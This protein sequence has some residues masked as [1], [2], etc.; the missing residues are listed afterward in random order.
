[1][2]RGPWPSRIAIAVGAVVVLGAA[3][4]VIVK[5]RGHEPVASGVASD[6]KV[7]IP[8]RGEVSLIADVVTP[9]G[10]GR[11][12]LVIMPT[13]WGSEITEY[14]GLADVLARDGYQVVTYVQR[15]FHQSGGQADFAGPP[16]QRDVSTVIDWAVRHTHG[17][18]K[19]VGLFGTSYGAGISLLAAA[20]DPRIKAVV[21]TSGWA[22]FGDVFAG[23]DTVRSA[24]L[25][26]LLG[27]VTKYGKPA[28]SLRNLAATL[29]SNRPADA[30]AQIRSMSPIR[31]ADREIAALNRNQPAIMLTSAY[32][33]SI[34]PPLS[35][36]SFFDRL[37]GP[38]RLQLAPG[39]HG[40]PEG[41]GLTGK[42]NAVTDQAH[43]W[44]DH[45]LK[46][47]PNGID[48]EPAVQ[49]TDAVTRAV[50]QYAKW[51]VA[52]ARVV[53]GRP[54]GPTA[55]ASAAATTWSQAIGGGTDTNADAVPGS[56]G[57]DGAYDPASIR[58]DRFD[59]AHG[60]YWTG[61]PVTTDTVLDG[62]PRLSLRV[63]SST[64]SASIFAHLYDVDAEGNASLMTAAPYTVTGAMATPERISFDLGPIGWTLAKG[65]RLALAIDTVDP[66]WAGVTTPGS[67]IRFSSTAAAPATLTL[68]LSN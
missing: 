34:L 26:A 28:D 50:K 47:E 3:I 65:H 20:R 55:A 56:T 9:R 68:P 45:Y 16:T 17:D 25:G 32:Q 24:A 59:R 58:L 66:R 63:S 15:G 53:L 23:N 38:K 51:P 37:K 19:H 5:S 40:V 30:A 12:P 18:E 14:H 31:S 43:E 42:P 36:I 61:D 29:R 33:D 27:S 6:T 13:S 10:S 1:M 54:D 7:R 22:D 60:V 41:A 4:V 57:P 35:L 8:V 46:A 49:F 67:L 2:L 64:G 62:A 11:F 44:L 21:A 52:S 48:E 39:D